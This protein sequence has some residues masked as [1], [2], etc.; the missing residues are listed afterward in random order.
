MIKQFMSYKVG[1]GIRFQ[2]TVMH[3]AFYLVNIR[4]KYI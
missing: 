3:S 2:P 1:I 4:L